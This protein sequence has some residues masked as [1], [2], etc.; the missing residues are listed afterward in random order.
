MKKVSTVW[1]QQTRLVGSPMPVQ[2]ACSC[3]HHKGALLTV[4]T[5]HADLGIECHATASRLEYLIATDS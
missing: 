1:T 2:I 5:R 3:G 4:L